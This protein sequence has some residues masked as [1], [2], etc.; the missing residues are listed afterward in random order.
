VPVVE[1]RA[2]P[3]PGVD[4]DAVAAHVCEAVA[5]LLGEEPS[6]TWATWQTLAYTEGTDARFEQPSDTHPP[7]V[8]VTA[9]E[10]RPPAVVR[11]IL[12]T[13]ADTLGRELGLDP[14]NVF[15]VYDEVCA[16]R[17]YTGGSVR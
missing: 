4:T 1:I 5:S 12:E 2:L 14:G 9:F 13:V 6:G 16:G 11:G 17:L 10:G 3:Q 8:R 7:L 15:V